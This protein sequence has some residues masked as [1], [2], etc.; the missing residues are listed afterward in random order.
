MIAKT[1]NWSFARV[2]PFIKMRGF[3]SQVILS[4]G[5]LDLGLDFFLGCVGPGSGSFG[6]VPLIGCFIPG[7][8]GG[9]KMHRTTCSPSPRPH[10]GAPGS[11]PTDYGTPIEDRGSYP[12]RTCILEGIRPRSSIWVLKVGGPG[13]LWGYRPAPRPL[14]PR[15]GGTHVTAAGAL[16]LPRRGHSCYRGGSIHFPVGNGLSTGREGPTRR[17][18]PRKSMSEKRCSEGEGHVRLPHIP[19]GA[20]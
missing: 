8:Q 9:R 19:G 1:E 18:A 15:G 13:L 3:P 5:V 12:A 4:L 17:E 11:G 16:M 14:R 6:G 20:V 2:Q 10:G 7:A